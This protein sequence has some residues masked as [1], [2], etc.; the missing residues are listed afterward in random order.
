VGP[1][2]LFGRREEEAPRVSWGA[3]RK[4][5]DTGPA[6][7]ICVKW[8]HQ[9]DVEVIEREKRDGG[10]GADVNIEWEARVAR[11]CGLRSLY[12]KRVVE[13][14]ATTGRSGGS[15]LLPKE[16]GYKGGAWE[17]ARSS[18]G[19]RTISSQKRKGSF[20]P[21][22]SRITLHCRSHLT[23]KKTRISK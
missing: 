7:G 8:L 21:M 16:L 22:N 12:K 3:A 14:P 9:S 11:I 6:L 2:T 17:G 1:L 15:I 18:S 13:A 5:R 20:Y 19:D 10:G 23:K 4:L